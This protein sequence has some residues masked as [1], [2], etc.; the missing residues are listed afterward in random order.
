MRIDLV[1]VSVLAVTVLSACAQ[2]PPPAAPRNA[3]P[4]TESAAVDSNAPSVDA[5]E[6]AQPDPSVPSDVAAPPADATKTPSGL[7]YKVLRPGTG[8]QHPTAASTVRVHYTGWTTD[9]KE[10]DSSV[11]RGQPLSFPLNGVI[12]GWTEGVQL[13]VLGERRRFWIPGALAYGETPNGKRP[14]GM[15]VFDVE[16]LGIE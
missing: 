10:F 5:V 12:K 3:A 9:G 4:A 16:L 11:R 14:Y 8:T 1:V 15:L 7:A 6:P 13:M 2:P